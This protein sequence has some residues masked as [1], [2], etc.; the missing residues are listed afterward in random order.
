MDGTYL[1]SKPFRRLLQRIVINIYHLFQSVSNP[2]HDRWVRYYPSILQKWKL[3]QSK[4]KWLAHK[5]QTSILNSGPWTSDPRIW[6]PLQAL[7]QCQSFSGMMQYYK[8]TSRATDGGPAKTNSLQTRAWRSVL[9]FRT[10]S[11]RTVSSFLRDGENNQFKLSRCSRKIVVSVS[12][13]DFVCYSKGN[14]ETL[15]LLNILQ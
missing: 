11:R 6:L 12:M 1:T 5:W 14:R 9:I 10:Q 8:I 3:S 4:N 15:N 7:F 2:Y 13:K